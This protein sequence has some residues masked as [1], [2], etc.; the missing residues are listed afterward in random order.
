MFFGSRGEL[1][2]GGTRGGEQPR[3]VSDREVAA[4]PQRDV[5]SVSE[6]LI[7]GDHVMVHDDTIGC[8]HGRTRAFRPPARRRAAAG[9]GSA[10]EAALAS[11]VIDGLQLGGWRA[12]VTV[13][14]AHRLPPGSDC[15]NLGDVFALPEDA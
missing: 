5:H 13:N 8:A 12:Q 6:R 11:R 4:Q 2:I 1:D 9:L 7:A 3:G 14:E 15:L 10:A